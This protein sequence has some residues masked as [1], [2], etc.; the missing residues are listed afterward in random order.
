MGLLQT[1]LNNHVNICWSI[2]KHCVQT[3]FPDINGKCE[4]I[5]RRKIHIFINCFPGIQTE[6]EVYNIFVDRKHL[7]LFHL[8]S[9]MT[10]E[11]NARVVP[12]CA[13][14][15]PGMWER[16]VTISS[17]GKIFSATGW[18][19]GWSI[20]PANLIHCQQMIH[21][22]CLYT[23]PTMLQVLSTQCL[24]NHTTGTVNSM[25]A[26]PYHRYCKLNACPTIPQVL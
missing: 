4:A 16:T 24:P 13:A 10:E 22:N 8:I 7:Y 25:P 18:K 3:I 21:Q 5:R 12:F 20:G 2:A 11:S 23:C 1:P 14:S 15:L 17:A 26:Q 19:L 6:R 9:N